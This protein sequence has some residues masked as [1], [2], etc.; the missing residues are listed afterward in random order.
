M[1]FKKSGFQVVGF[2]IP[3][4]FAWLEWDLANFLFQFFATVCKDPW[5]GPVQKPWLRPPTGL[6]TASE[7]PPN[8]LIGMFNA[9]GNLKQ[10]RF[11]VGFKT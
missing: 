7:R 10:D 1:C 3:T 11:T 8:D 5:R 4:V 9:K 2:Q 6:R